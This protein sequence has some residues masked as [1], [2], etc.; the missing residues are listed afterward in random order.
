MKTHLPLL[1]A[2]GLL[3]CLP[4]CF[5][6]RQTPPNPEAEVRKDTVYPLGFLTDTLLQRGY[7]IRYGQTL[8][9]VL[10]E[11]GATPADAY[12]LTQICDSVFK[13]N[14][15]FR[16]HDS[17][18]VYYADTT[19]ASLRYI[20]YPQNAVR[21]TVF[22]CFDSLAV[23]KVEKEVTHERRISDIRIE[24]SLW[25]A[26]LA[27][28]ASPDLIMQLADIYAWTID[29][30]SLQKGDR[31]RVIY[32]QETC[33][34]QPLRV[35][36]V[37]FSL[38]TGYGDKRAAAIYLDQKDG[39]KY[40]NEKGI[41]LRNDKGF[42]KAPLQFKRIS[43]GFGVRIHPITGRRKMHPA[44]DYAAPTGTPVHT[45]GDGVVTFAGWDKG[46]GGN[47]ISITHDRKGYVT[48][49]LHLSKFAAGIRAGV[50]VKQGQTIG[51]VGST[52]RST[53]PHLDFRITKDGK[54]VNPL[55]IVSATK[56]EGVPIKK[57]NKAQ[58]DSL[59]ARYI[60]EIGE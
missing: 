29:F 46:G 48:K 8:S 10:Q 32:N 34:G 18:D 3:L 22:K 58:L 30:F 14:R 44:I 19:L 23:W 56:P 24:T 41:S 60:A 1:A 20:V 28:G 25:D 2:L 26:L 52:G 51:Y 15:D 55:K 40:W 36:T 45:I 35:D 59:Y 42:L 43:S 27:D 9:G 50:R 12:T 57:E 39:N 16:A 5:C 49:Y 54:P 4:G 31:F 37:F 11:L 53:G 6:K 13:V 33:E 7:R 47:Y 21:S 17:L 38:Y